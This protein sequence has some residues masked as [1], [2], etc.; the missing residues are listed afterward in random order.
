MA[1]RKAPDKFPLRL[2]PTRAF[3]HADG[4]LRCSAE[5]DGDDPRLVM[6]AVGP[7]PVGRGS[8]CTGRGS[9]FNGG[10]QN[11]VRLRGVGRP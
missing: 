10:R 11:A 4:D 8:S 3:L 2:H 9:S 5:A 1:T 6:K 7:A